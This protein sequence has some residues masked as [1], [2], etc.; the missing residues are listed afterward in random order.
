MIFCNSPVAYDFSVRDFGLRT[1]H[2]DLVDPKQD[3]QWSAFLSQVCVSF[4]KY[5]VVYIKC[6]TFKKSSAFLTIDFVDFLNV[7]EANEISDPMKQ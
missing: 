5:L 6:Y 2:E 4:K 3:D 1:L 7:R